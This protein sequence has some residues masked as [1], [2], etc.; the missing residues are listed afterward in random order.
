[1]RREYES[2]SSAI[3]LQHCAKEERQCGFIRRAR[4]IF[5]ML[6]ERYRESE[7][8]RDVVSE[9]LVT[10]GFLFVH[11]GDKDHNVDKAIELFREADRLGNIRAPF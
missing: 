6:I 2:C 11:I 10:L 7:E 3:E 1:M 8:D 5:E 9:S 4:I